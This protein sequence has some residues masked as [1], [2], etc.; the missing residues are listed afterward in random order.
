MRKVCCFWLLAT[1]LWLVTGCAKPQVEPPQTEKPIEAGAFYS[2]AKK[3]VESAEN[4]LLDYTLT[5][6]RTVGDNT[7][8]KQTTGRASYRDD[9]RNGMQAQVEETLDFGYYRC[10]Y[11]EIYQK[12]KAYATINGSSFWANQSPE[13][14]VTR[15]LPPVLLT[16]V[17]YDTVTY[18]E[19]RETVLFSDPRGL[20]A[21][22]GEG[23][24]VEAFGQAKFHPDGQLLQTSYQVLYRKA[25]AEISLSVTVHISMPER[26]ELAQIQEQDCV[27]LSDLDA[28]RRLVQVV[29]EVYSAQNI[30]CVLTETIAS[31]AI[32]L[33]YNRNTDMVIYGRGAN[34]SAEVSTHSQLSNNRGVITQ[35]S[36]TE[37]FRDQSYQVSADGNSPVGNP[38][39]TADVMRQYCEDT[40]LSGLLAVKYL[41]SV[42]VSTDGKLLHLELGGDLVFREIMTKHLQDIL[43]VDLDA[44]AD[45]SEHHRSG[46]YLTVDM[47]TGL[48]VGLGMYLEKSHTI[49]GVAY[50]L[51]YRLEEALNFS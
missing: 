31:E 4:L 19:T 1:L 36:Q 42:S 2:S 9:G 45:A 18:G 49:D 23:Q 51:E 39:V 17:L 38:A 24:V 47:Q 7:F 6:T 43:Q 10:D 37:L 33:S 8:T 41:R 26:L 11:R 32:P 35:S 50:K 15:Q 48:P 16:P 34:L 29:A 5:E 30:S 44:L 3:A 40:I 12:D 25:E 46:G 14:F 13:A 27:W 20:E 28:P 21:W 22:V